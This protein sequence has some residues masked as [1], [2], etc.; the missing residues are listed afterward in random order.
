[1]DKPV[2]LVTGSAHRIGRATAVAFAKKG[3]KGRR[4]TVGATVRRAR[5][6]R[7]VL[8]SLGFGGRLHPRRRPQRR[9]G[10]RPRRRKPS[11]GSEPP[12]RRGEQRRHRRPGRS[13]H[14]PDRGDLRREPSTRTSSAVILSMKHEVRAMQDR[15]AAASSTSPRPTGTR[16]APG[17]LSVLSAASTA[18][19][20]YTK[21]VALE[22]R[23]VRI[24]V[25]GVAPGSHGHRHVD[26]RFNR[27]AGEQGGAGDRSCRWAASASPRS[28]PTAVVFISSDEAS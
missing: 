3:A 4:P 27:H 1:M 26:D 23:R 5:R 6:S 12:R 25:N 2:V 18:S 16:G 19:K 24:R 8:R 13:D 11:R 7:R 28:S 10:P 17:G 9:R 22:D 20:A 14:R 21:F 15:A